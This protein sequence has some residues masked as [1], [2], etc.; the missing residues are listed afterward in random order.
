MNW[1]DSVW[2]RVSGWDGFA[3][4]LS[5]FA[6]AFTQLTNLPNSEQQRNRPANEKARN[7]GEKDRPSK[8]EG[9]GWS[10]MGILES[11]WMR[12]HGCGCTVVSNNSHLPRANQNTRLR[13]E[14]IRYDANP[15]YSYIAIEPSSLR[16]LVWPIYIDTVWCIVLLVDC[17]HLFLVGVGVVVL[18][19]FGKAK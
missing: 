15:G 10:R 17:C 12:G 6:F 4:R 19:H 18:I 8:R 2:V 13:N 1:F 5:P 16:S 3:F 7:G 9:E 11:W 14:T